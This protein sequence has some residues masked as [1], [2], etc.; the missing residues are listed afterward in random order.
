VKTITKTSAAVRGTVP[1]RRSLLIRSGWLVAGVVALVGLFF[2]QFGAP[3]Q[4]RFSR[5]S[6]F[7]P[8]L[9]WWAITLA[10]ITLVGV[11]CLVVAVFSSRLAR[12]LTSPLEALTAASEKLGQRDFTHTEVPE[13]EIA[14]IGRLS[15]ALEKTSELLLRHDQQISSQ[16]AH[17]RRQLEALSATEEKF[18]ESMAYNKVLYVDSPTPLLTLDPVT[19]RFVDCNPAAAR[20]LGVPDLAA[21]IG[22]APEDFSPPCQYDGTPTD[23]AATDAIKAAL[24][25]GVTIREWHH[26][27]PNGTEWDSEIHLM[28]FQSSGRLLVQCS[29]QDI[30]QRKQSVE[31]LRQLALHDTLTGLFNRSMFIERLREALQTAHATRQNVAVLYLDLDRF[32]EINDTQGHT[33]GDS[34]LQ[35]VAGRFRSTLR[36]GEILARLGGDEFAILANQT[37]S[38]AAAAIAEHIIASLS[39]RIEIGSQ[40]FALGVSVGIAHF[41]EDGDS[42]DT[43]LRNADVA[44]YRAKSGGRGY[45]HY[46][47]AMSAGIAERIA[48]ARDLKDALRH[49]PEQLSLYYQPQFDLRSGRLLGAESLIRWTHPTLG[50]LIPDVFIPVAEAR[51]MMSMIGTWVLQEACRQIRVW[52]ENGHPFTGRMAINIAAQQIED[53]AFPNRIHEI[54]QAAGIGPRL[55]E[56]ELTESGMMKNIEQSIAM[57]TQ[58]NAIGFSLAIDDFGTGYSSL[59]YLKRLPARKLKIDKSFVRDMV[60]DDNDRTIVTTI[61]AMG[62][63][64]GMHTIA[65]G[66]ETREQ[67]D[68]LIA[69]GCDGVQGY[70]YGEPEPASTFAEKWLPANHAASR[71]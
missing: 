35:E 30:T 17:L 15:A 53:A 23:I 49:H 12:Q 62:K 50:P 59:S 39:P 10:M 14:E 19:G 4:A 46:A 61:I 1:L 67:A 21:V 54:L 18:R 43:L 38:A 6:A 68:A 27:R 45:M 34:V 52:R 7:S 13:T 60:N 9:D 22:M 55:F 69:L 44:M 65:E 24:E 66:V 57:F 8:P 26:R 37:D 16:E 25:R 64:L 47:P 2:L 36:N 71:G 40:S 51:G 33:V 5:S 63:T 3:L 20:I 31:A 29:I 42:P 41:P 58:L 11:L 32:K 48:L 28:P 70:L 56:L